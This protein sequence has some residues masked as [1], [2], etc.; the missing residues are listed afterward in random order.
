MNAWWL[1][2]V[3]LRA[4][5]AKCAYANRLTLSAHFLLPLVPETSD[6]AKQQC[7]IHYDYNR[8][9]AAAQL[10]SFFHYL[11]ID[12]IYLPRHICTAGLDT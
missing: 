2:S 9:Q 5:G 12:F 8:M 4:R 3:T 10:S 6:D 11:A 7:L 1:S